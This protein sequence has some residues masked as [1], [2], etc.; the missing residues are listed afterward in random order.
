MGNGFD[1]TCRLRRWARTHPRTSPVQGGC[2]CILSFFL[3]WCCLLK[4]LKNLSENSNS[5]VAK[6]V[7]KTETWAPHKTKTLRESQA[8][9]TYKSPHDS[10]SVALWSVPKIGGETHPT[11]LPYGLITPL[12]ERLLFSGI[13]QS[14]RQTLTALPAPEAEVV[15]LL[16]HSRLLWLSSKASQWMRCPAERYVQQLWEALG[17]VSKGGRRV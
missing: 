3:L 15:A 17:G 5:P 11:S 13:W 7:P 14:R 6:S 9:G 1:A 2:F 12:E 10:A 16:R 4:C 8:I